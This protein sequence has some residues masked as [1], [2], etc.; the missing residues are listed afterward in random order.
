MMY[1]K[2]LLQGA[3]VTLIFAGLNIYWSHQQMSYY[4]AII[5]AIIVIVYLVYA[6]KE[7]WL[8]YYGKATA[9]LA[10]VAMLAV[11]P[12]VGILLPTADY[13]KESMRG[14]SAL[15]AADSD[16]ATGLDGMTIERRMVN[17]LET[18]TATTASDSLASKLDLIYK[19]LLAGQNIM[20]DGK[21]L[22]GSTA[23]RYDTELG[24]RRVL[25]ERGAL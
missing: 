15:K 10:V 24:Q 21:T 11:A 2:K 7:K 22:V 16:G 3:L 13:S 17:A 14:G 20:L 8:P 18:G 4:T 25:A 12:A 1:R 5:A 23:L 6:I 19:A 9:V